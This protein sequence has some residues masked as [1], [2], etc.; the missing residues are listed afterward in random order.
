MRAKPITIATSGRNSFTFN[1]TGSPFERLRSNLRAKVVNT[2]RT[3]PEAI[4]IANTLLTSEEMYA[5]ILIR[6]IS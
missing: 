5:I 3:I 6:I 4:P 2:T 1:L